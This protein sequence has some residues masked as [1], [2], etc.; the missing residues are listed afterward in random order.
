[1]GRADRRHGDQSWY[2]S[3]A[4]AGDGDGRMVVARPLAFDTLDDIS[5]GRAR[6]YHRL[7]LGNHIPGTFITVWY[8]AAI[9]IHSLPSENRDVAHP[10]LSFDRAA[11]SIHFISL[12]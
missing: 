12:R 4:Y 1:M 7:P 6:C 5:L 11:G 8:V 10:G 3:C 2:Y 9:A